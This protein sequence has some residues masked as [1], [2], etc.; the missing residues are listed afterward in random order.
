[1]KVSDRF[2]C[3]N[4]L[5]QFV[6]ICFSGTAVHVRSLTLLVFMDLTIKY[7]KLRP[8]QRPPLETAT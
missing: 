8:A 3:K 4:E 1:M 7:E 5:W 6:R 2:Q